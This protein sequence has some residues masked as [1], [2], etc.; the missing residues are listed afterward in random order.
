LLDAT[1]TLE[2]DGAVEM[3]NED[4]TLDSGVRDKRGG[5][6]G[7]LRVMIPEGEWAWFDAVVLNAYKECPAQDQVDRRRYLRG[8]RRF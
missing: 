4:D 6:G 2:R 7:M 3:P 8:R 5:E 1:S